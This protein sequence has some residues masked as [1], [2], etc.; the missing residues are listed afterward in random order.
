MLLTDE[1]QQCQLIQVFRQGSC[2]LTNRFHFSEKA[3]RVLY[4][5]FLS[6]ERRRRG[7]VQPKVRTRSQT[8]AA[9]VAASVLHG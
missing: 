1:Q 3:N 8:C 5:R 6:E 2:S 9:E 7:H 4:K